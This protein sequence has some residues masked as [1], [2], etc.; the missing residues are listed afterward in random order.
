MLPTADGRVATTFPPPRAATF[1]PV[2]EAEGLPAVAAHRGSCA[3]ADPRV[4]LR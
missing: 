4:P 3:L 2:R 1:L